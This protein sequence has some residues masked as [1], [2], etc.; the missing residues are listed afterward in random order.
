MPGNLVFARPGVLMSA[1]FDLERQALTGPETVVLDAVRTETEGDG[2][3]PEPQAVFSRDG[4][5]VYAQGGAFRKSTRAVW[6]DRQGKVQPLGMPAR[7]YRAAHLSPDGRFLALIIADLRNDLWVQDLEHGTLTQRTFGAEP[8]GVNWTPDGERITFG[9]RRNGKRAFSLLR[10]GSSEPEPFVTEDGQPGFG[11]FSPDG[12]LVATVKGDPT[13]GLDLWVLSLKGPQ[14][15]QPFLRTRFTEVGPAFSPDGRWIA[16]ASD[17]SGQYE[18]YV[19]PYPGPG[20]EW[21]VSSKGGEHVSWSRDGKEL[22]YRDGP[23]VMSVAVNLTSDFTAA[24][25][26]LLFEGPYTSIDVS[27]DSQR[28][29]ALEPVEAQIAPLTHLNIVLNWFEDVR[30]KTGIAPDDRR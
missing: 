3:A 18:I 11:S 21:Q 22:F 7:S 24:L 4:T 9:S 5:L 6:V 13:T 16:Y 2:L 10:D 23:K 8:E 17:K 19:R 27:P 28:F 12:K 14:I 30:R 29:L 26:R 1:S 15:Q 25:L 20:G